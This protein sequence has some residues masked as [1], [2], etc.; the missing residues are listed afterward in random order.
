MV[1]SGVVNYLLNN[2]LLRHGYSLNLKERS[3]TCARES[4]INCCKCLD[5]LGLATNRLVHL[6][7]LV[8]DEG[9]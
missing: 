5:L 2:L 7:R 1:F 4:I 3:D 9:R 6:P 8:F